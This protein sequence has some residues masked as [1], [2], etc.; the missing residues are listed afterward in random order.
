M[1]CKNL[2]IAALLHMFHHSS[3]YGCYTMPTVSVV[4]WVRQVIHK[5]T[6]FILLS[7]NNQ[8][9]GLL[10][11]PTRYGMNGWDDA[12]SEECATSSTL[13]YLCSFACRMLAVFLA[14]RLWRF[15]LLIQAATL[16][17]TQ[18]Q[19]R[20]RRRETDSFFSNKLRFLPTFSGQHLPFPNA[21]APALLVSVDPTR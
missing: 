17:C 10:P 18:P 11:A 1:Y 15:S 16:M 4:A 7:G 5:T 6:V 14:E 19:S 21:Q 13:L 12:P 8:Q 2:R 3:N 9:R 20:S